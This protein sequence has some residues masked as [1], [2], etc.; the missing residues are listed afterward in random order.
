MHVRSLTYCGQQLSH[1]RLRDR[2]GQVPI[3]ITSIIRTLV[4]QI[5]LKLVTPLP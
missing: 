5:G 4:A 1:L 2:N 3:R